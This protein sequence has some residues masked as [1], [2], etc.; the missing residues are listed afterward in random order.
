[1]NVRHGGRET[2][3]ISGRISKRRRMGEE[4][5]LQGDPGST[6]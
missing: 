2:T 4:H 1:M 3:N 5:G 6:Q